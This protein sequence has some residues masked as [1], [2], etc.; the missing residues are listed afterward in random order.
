MIISKDGNTAT[1]TTPD[2]LHFHFRHG[3]LKEVLIRMLL[4]NGWRG[5][6]VGEPN[7]KPAQLTGELSFA[8]AVEA[9]QIA[10]QINRELELPN[11]ED[12]QPLPVLQINEQTTVKDVRNAYSLEVRICKVYPRYV[13]TNSEDGVY[14]YLNIYAALREAA[15]LGMVVQ[16][17]A[18]HPS[19]AEE[20]LSKEEEFIRQILI[21]IRKEIPDLKLTIEHISS[22]FGVEWV[23][24]EDST[25]VAA[26]VTVQHLFDTVDDVLGYSE[27]SRGKI[28]PHH[29]YKPHAKFLADRQAIRNAILSGHPR[30]FSAD[31]G[32]WHLKSDKECADCACGAGNTLASIPKILDL[33]MSN[34]V[35]H[36]AEGFL[37]YLG[38]EYYGLPTENRGTVSFTRKEWVIPKEIP[39]PELKDSLV[40]WYAGM[41]VPWQIVK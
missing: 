25:N 38:A 26:G 40:P 13:T 5:R 17:H 6:V 29:G 8:H 12:F 3:H 2:N 30:F 27:K 23:I 37:S 39:V 35:L 9:L 36:R 21:P 32:A 34:G 15:R 20:G 33:F 11:F 10:Y 1:F 19:Y 14:D 7:T 16:L 41:P 22:E 18:E 28:Q 4:E 24:E 31:D